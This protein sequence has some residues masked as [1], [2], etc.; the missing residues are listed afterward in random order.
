LKYLFEKK[1]AVICAI[2]FISCIPVC[3]AAEPE[4][5]IAAKAKQWEPISTGAFADSIHHVIMRYEERKPP[6]KQYKTEQIIHIAENLLAWQN[7]DGGWPKNKDWLK[8]MS[9]E[10]LAALPQE[11]NENPYNFS[12][13]DNGSTWSQI[14]YLARVWQRTGLKRYADGALKGIHYI[15]ESQRDSGGW[16]GADVEPIGA[17]SFEPSSIVTSESV[18]V[19][20]LLMSIDHPTPDIIDAVQAAVTWFKKVGIEGLRLE[21]KPSEP[22]KFTYH[23]ANFDLVEVQDPEA[24]IIWTRYYDLKT[25]EP[26]FCTRKGEITKNFT[27][28]S[29]ER[30]TGYAWYGYW[31]NRVLESSYPEWQQKWAPLQSRDQIEN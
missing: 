17:R 9:P 18:G 21:K 5:V 6:Y 23:W 22:V 24:P 27:D 16:R 19:V 10:E 11:K 29:M 14:D 13:L 25:E 26:I 2:I 8:I 28:L 7:S 4:E 12:T 31:P 30:R 15:L 20:S 3:I 1:L